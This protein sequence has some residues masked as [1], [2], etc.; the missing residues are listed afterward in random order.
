M[1]KKSQIV[2]YIALVVFVATAKAQQPD[3]LFEWPSPEWESAAVDALEVA[4]ESCYFF[5]VN[6]LMHPYYY[7][8]E[9]AS[10]AKVFKVSVE[11]ELLDSVEVGMEGR[12]TFVQK[13]FL[14]P[15]DDKSCL[16]VG[17]IHDNENHYDKPFMAKFDLDLN[18]MWLKEID[19][20][21]GYQMYLHCMNA[22]V[23]SDGCAFCAMTPIRVEQDGNMLPPYEN[24]RSHPLYY[25][26]SA[27]GELLATLEYPEWCPFLSP[28]GPMFE[29]HDGSGDYGQ[30]VHDYHNG[31]Y[32]PDS[33][34]V[35]IS[36]NLE[37][38]GHFELPHYSFV[39]QSPYYALFPFFD[40]YSQGVSF[41]D[42]T[43][44][45]G[46]WGELLHQNYDS[47][48]VI[49]LSKFDQN[50]EV[51]S[52]SSVGQGELGQTNDSLKVMLTY[53]SMDL[54]GDDAFYFCYCIG[55]QN[56]W[57]VDWVDH[58]S[59]VKM[60]ADLNVVWQRYWD[61]Y[62]P[63][64]GKKVYW[65]YYMATTSDEGCFVTGSCYNSDRSEYKAFVLKFFSDGSLSVPEMEDFVRP[66]AYYPNPVQDELHL[67]YSPDITPTQIELYD[68]QGRMVRTQRNGLESLSMKGLA[69]G[70]YT[71]RV[72]LEDGKV[73]V[74]KIIKE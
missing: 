20:P 28:F 49:T 67:Q 51:V 3:F 18:L 46:A 7:E 60:D 68:L 8:T 5:A 54:V 24:G 13:L 29:Y 30:V 41:P 39:S 32:A 61:K 70:A 59:L 36:R 26:L 48:D 9:I 42:G 15:E 52:Y 38:T 31:A 22:L 65:P 55:E 43:K 72:V 66:Y 57:G 33:Y 19:L 64:Y 58:F 16:A 37:L 62:R 12:Y 6:K 34:L 23:D 53:Q 71:M 10:P 69:S 35:R 2:T 45:L 17:K 44:V 27:E 50:N 4:S 47:E 21:E 73:F 1:K 11:G 14:H 63:E 74:D 56:G 40:F 25:R